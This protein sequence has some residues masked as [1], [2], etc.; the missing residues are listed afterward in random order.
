[1]VVSKI[2][3]ALVALAGLSLL[4]LF[5]LP[6]WQILLWAPQYPEGLGMHIWINRIT[7]IGPN[8]LQNIN[9]LNHY[10]GMHEIRPDGIPELRIFPWIVV[11]LAAGAVAVAA[12]GRRWLLY[13][14]GAGFVAFAVLGLVDFYRWEHDYGHDLDPNAAIRIPGASYQPPLIGSRQILNFVADSW[15]A[16]GGWVAIAAGFTAVA[17]MAFELY[18]SRTRREGTAHA[19]ATREGAVLRPGADAPAGRLRPGT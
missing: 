7:G 13:A 12:L 6:L 14:W 16:A 8:D 2:S 11:A 18:R 10:I 19:D 9:G 17:V 15:P 5:V 4:L 3:R 1:V